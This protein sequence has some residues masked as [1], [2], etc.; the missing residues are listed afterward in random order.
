MPST[1]KE[2]S[3]WDVDEKRQELLSLFHAHL[4]HSSPWQ[5]ANGSK[6]VESKVVFGDGVPL[7]FAR[8][9]VDCSAAKLFD[10]L[11]MSLSETC[12]E[13]N[14]AMY[15]SS[16]L[17]D[18]EARKARVTTIISDGSPVYD[19]EDVFLQCFC[20]LDRPAGAALCEL[21][22]GI[23]MERV[24]LNVSGKAKRPRR[25]VRS[26]MPFAAKLIEPSID[27]ASCTYTTV[28]QYDPK[29][30]LSLLP[31]SMLAN[32]LLKNLVHEHERLREIFSGGEKAKRWRLVG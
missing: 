20:E 16:V 24:E 17:A 19:R 9:S 31:S 22:S 32:I 27:G 8:T 15:H 12:S 7:L 5:P 10:Y 29:G 2:L 4:A 11:V 18:D 3:G 28:W 26:D 6:H 14:D 25:L 23:G 21:S 30:W 1:I 13:W